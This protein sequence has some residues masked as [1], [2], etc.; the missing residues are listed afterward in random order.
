MEDSPPDNWIVEVDS[1][2][3]CYGAVHALT[4]VSLGLAEGQCTAI[5][6]DNGAGKS[7]LVK[8]ISGVLRPDSGALYLYGNAYHPSGP[9]DA[10]AVGVET[11]Y[12]DLALCDSLDAVANIFLGREL[13]VG[14]PRPLRIP[15]RSRMKAQVDE[16][17]ERTG[18][19]LPSTLTT[20]R[21]L[22]GG[23]RQGLAIARALAWR[24]RLIVLDEPTAALGV[25]ETA[26]V[27]ELIRT[28]VS[29][30]VS[31]ALVS[32]N[33]EQVFRVASRVVVMR[34]GRAVLQRRVCDT[35]PEEVV[36]FITGAATVAR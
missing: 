23:Q 15:R 24:A 33:M 21:E 25:R 30:D 8:I 10:R 11:V 13:G 28:V 20:V 31:V 18:V 27:E 7:T 36:A 2:S 26:H 1:V 32:H 5:V 16:L 12:Q 19:N 14:W 9:A 6:G 3:K 35:N 34:Q 4:Q 22:S 29:Q 17:I